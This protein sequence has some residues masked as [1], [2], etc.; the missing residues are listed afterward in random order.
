MFPGL[1]YVHQNPVRHGLVP[2]PNQDRWCSAAWFE[3]TA[4]PA[5]VKTSDS[6][7]ID[8]VNALDDFDVTVD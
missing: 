8:R 3:H 1:D 2:V 7:E 5:Q 6:P 4:K